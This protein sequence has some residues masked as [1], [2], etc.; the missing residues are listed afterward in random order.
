MPSAKNL[1]KCSVSQ[2]VLLIRFHHYQESSLTWLPRDALTAGNIIGPALAP[3]PAN[4][5]E[6]DISASGSASRT[7]VMLSDLVVV[8]VVVVDLLLY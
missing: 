8:V 3:F 5:E 2:F 7:R 6:M 4:A 1:M